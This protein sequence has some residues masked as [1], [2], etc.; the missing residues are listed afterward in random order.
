[1]GDPRGIVSIRG[2]RG[3]V[4]VADRRGRRNLH[5]VT[6][7]VMLLIF[8]TMIDLIFTSQYFNPE[9]KIVKGHFR[10]FMKIKT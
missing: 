3:G 9:Q 5:V 7:G 4:R 2:V 1:M 10:K 8:V 6:A